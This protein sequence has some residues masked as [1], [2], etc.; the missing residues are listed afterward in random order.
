MTLDEILTLGTTLADVQKQVRELG[1][2]TADNTAPSNVSKISKVPFR[3]M[4]GEVHGLLRGTQRKNFNRQFDRACFA[5]G[6]R[7]HLKGDSACRATNA[8]CLKCGEIGHFINR[9][10]KRSITSRPAT[11]PPTS[12][13]IRCVNEEDV[14]TVD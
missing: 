2:Q 6:R 11:G 13:A 5:C 10:L 7:G 8:K 1:R 14:E 3:E 9:C 4:R 12:K